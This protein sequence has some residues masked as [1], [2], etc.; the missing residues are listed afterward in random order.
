MWAGHYEGIAILAASTLLAAAQSDEIHVS[1]HPYVPPQI[2][3]VV[4]SDL[5]QIE[6][7]VRDPRGHAMSGLK[8]S[9]FEIL[10]EGKPR[11]ITAF[12][13]TTRHRSTVRWR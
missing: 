1:A 2:R 3:L 11:E 7:A 10:D 5:V 12:S 13:V 9:D 8:Q 6:V 4:Q